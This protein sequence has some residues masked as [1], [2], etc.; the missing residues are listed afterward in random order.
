MGSLNY[1]RPK[2]IKETLALMEKGVPLAG[3]TAL[4]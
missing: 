1:H 4:T 3:G 2:T